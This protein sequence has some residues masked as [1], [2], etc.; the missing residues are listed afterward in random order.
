MVGFVSECYRSDRLFLWGF[1]QGETI[2]G[3]QLFSRATSGG[4]KLKKPNTTVPC[5]IATC[6]LFPVVDLGPVLVFY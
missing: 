2:Y 3:L 5:P 6:Q 1:S 4:L